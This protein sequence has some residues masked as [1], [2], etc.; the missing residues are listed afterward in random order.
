MINKKPLTEKTSANVSPKTG[1]TAYSS[2]KSG[3]SHHKITKS[4]NKHETPGKFDIESKKM[5][6]VGRPGHKE[7][8]KA[9]RK[10][11][12]G[13]PKPSEGTS[14]SESAASVASKKNAE[15]PKVSLDSMTKVKLMIMLYISLCKMKF[16]II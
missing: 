6:L 2:P 5:S 15:L 10:S 14:V 4:P 8:P 3:K 13:L 11:E 9:D 16:S 12:T 1:S 7:F